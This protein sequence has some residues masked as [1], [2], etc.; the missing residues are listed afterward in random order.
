MV[1]V[2]VVLSLITI[3]RHVIH[4]I[5]RPS[6]LPLFAQFCLSDRF[7]NRR[8]VVLVILRRV[9]KLRCHHHLLLGVPRAVVRVRSFSLIH[10]VEQVSLVVSS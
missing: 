10:K 4:R 6:S 3:Y 5:A 8:K 2:I 9:E 7:G 1:V